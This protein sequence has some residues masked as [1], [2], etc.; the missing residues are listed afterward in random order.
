MHIHEL[1]RFSDL[2][3]VW[4]I[5]DR[6]LFLYNRFRYFRYLCL[7]LALHLLLLL[8]FFHCLAHCDYDPFD[9]LLSALH[10]LIVHVL[11]IEKA[12]LFDEVLQQCLDTSRKSIKSGH[13]FLADN[14]QLDLRWF[15]IGLVEQVGLGVI[16][17]AL[18]D[19]LIIRELFLDPI[20]I[21][22]AWVGNCF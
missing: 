8:I 1:D 2:I 3:A 22:H 10:P 19:F 14:G 21:A 11:K 6:L 5:G 20:C 16:C 15:I 4:N 7:L 12:S 9:P 17:K 13:H 18:D